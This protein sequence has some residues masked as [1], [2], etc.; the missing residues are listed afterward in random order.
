MKVGL[1]DITELL[2]LPI[3]SAAV[4]VLWDL[5]KGVGTL[6][7]QVGVL[8]ANNATYEKRI[9]RLEY[10]LDKMESKESGNEA[11]R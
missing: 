8:I 7:V 10:R 9:E 4:F 3:L 11:Q 2:I 5:S 6:N 1:R